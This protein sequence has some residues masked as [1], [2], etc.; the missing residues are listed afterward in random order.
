MKNPKIISINIRTDGKPIAICRRDSEGRPDY[1]QTSMIALLNKDNPKTYQIS[2]IG[3][4]PFSVLALEKLSGSRLGES[5]D[6]LIGSESEKT[7]FTA[8]KEGVPLQVFS[9]DDSYLGSVFFGRSYD[10]LTRAFFDRREIISGQALGDLKIQRYSNSFC[11]ASDFQ[12]LKKYL[13]NRFETQNTRRA[14]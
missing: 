12:E 1:S 6:R 10:R 11:A 14:A 3:V 4:K 2:C 8:I 13:E 7:D 5:I 9:Q